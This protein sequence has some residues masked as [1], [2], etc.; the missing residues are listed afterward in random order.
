MTGKTKFSSF[1]CCWFFKTCTITVS[2]AETKYPVVSTVKLTLSSN[3]RDLVTNKIPYC[4]Q[5]QI[6]LNANRAIVWFLNCVN[7]SI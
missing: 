4:K 1:L 6:N 2:L 3:K 7:M 5:F